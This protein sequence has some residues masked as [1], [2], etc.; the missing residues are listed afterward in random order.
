MEAVTQMNLSF[1]TLVTT[2]I[3]SSFLFLIAEQRIHLAAAFDHGQTDR[4]C[5]KIRHGRLN[6]P[7]IRH[8]GVPC[9]K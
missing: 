9:L 8:G 2:F 7:K 6:W 4:P 5:L 1:E 3:A